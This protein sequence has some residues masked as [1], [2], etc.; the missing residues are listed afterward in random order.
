MTMK[1][2]L[3][4]SRLVDSLNERVGRLT[5]TISAIEVKDGVCEVT[6]TAIDNGKPGSWWVSPYNP[7]PIL[8][9]TFLDGDGR[10]LP[11]TEW[12][13]RSEKDT[14]NDVCR[15]PLKDGRTLAAI[16]I[17]ALGDFFC[18]EIP[19]RFADVPVPQW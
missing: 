3:A 11:C 4:F 5:V 19:F 10:T 16:E 12:R 8:S 15:I 17:A 13:H 18:V 2:L 6:Y 1:I 7:K 14:A 9:W